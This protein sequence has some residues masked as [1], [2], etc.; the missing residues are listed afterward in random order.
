MDH[1][2]P[3]FPIEYRHDGSIFNNREHKLP[4]LS[5][6]ETYTEWVV[7]TDGIKGPGAR[8]I[9]SGGGMMWYTRDHYKTFILIYP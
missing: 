2:S 5:N 1:A 3:N 9:V 6:G 4:P 7:P 8:R